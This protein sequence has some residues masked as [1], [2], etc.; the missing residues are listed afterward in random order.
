MRFKSHP[1]GVQQESPGRKPW[2]ER[3]ENRISPEGRGRAHAIHTFGR[4]ESWCVR[5]CAY[6]YRPAAP[7]LYDQCCY[8]AIQR[9]DTRSRK[10]LFASF[11]RA[12][13]LGAPF[14]RAF[15][16]RPFGACHCLNRRQVSAERASMRDCDLRSGLFREFWAV[17]L[18]YPRPCCRAGSARIP[19]AAPGMLRG[20]P[21]RERRAAGERGSGR[22]SR[23]PAGGA[24]IAHSSGHFAGIPD[25]LR[26]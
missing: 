26:K 11:F 17:R 19:R 18:Y 25:F 1:A 6:F 12:G 5:C 22:R 20:C 9:K 15:L 8:T 16:H 2:D 13:I 21:A 23:M 24:P 14:P 4:H 7:P 3:H 10:F